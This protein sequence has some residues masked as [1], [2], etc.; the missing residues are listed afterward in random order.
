[1]CTQ[2][3]DD[4]AAGMRMN[5]AARALGCFV[6]YP[7]QARQAKTVLSGC[8]GLGGRSIRSSGSSTYISPDITRDG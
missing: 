1:M 6:L 5:E 3:P 8:A 7:A 2:D 4:F